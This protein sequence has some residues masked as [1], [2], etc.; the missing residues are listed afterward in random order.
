MATPRKRMHA[1]RELSYDP[2]TSGVVWTQ[3]QR[4]VDASQIAA[5]RAGV[6]CR[7][8]IKSLEWSEEHEREWAAHKAARQAE[9]AR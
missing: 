7:N 3:C 1:K 8:C 5:F 2:Q 6:T 9:E 4:H